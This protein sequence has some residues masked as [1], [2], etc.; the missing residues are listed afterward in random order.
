MFGHVFI[1]LATSTAYWLYF[2]E[3]KMISYMTHV[4]QLTDVGGWAFGK[5][6]G[7]TPFAQRI[8]PKK[9]MEGLFGCLLFAV[10]ISIVFY[11]LG[12]TFDN[13]PYNWHCLKLP[14]WDYVV[15]GLI[16][17]SLSILGDLIESFLK[18]CADMKDSGT[19]MKS[20]G[21]FFDRIDSMMLAVPFLLWYTLQYDKF[22]N[23]PDYSFNKVHM[24]EFLTIQP[25]WA[26]PNATVLD[27]Y[28]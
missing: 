24:I 6:L 7:R 3:P 26:D 23:M 9:T 10:L 27:Q 4:T 8:S 19:G 20:H 21:G 12:N 11:Y 15:L 1:T 2:L 5:W 13:H 14:F 25:R 18:R 22:R 28:P 17:G 16:C